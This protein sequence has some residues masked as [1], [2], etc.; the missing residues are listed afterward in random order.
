[1]LF[2]MQNLKFESYKQTPQERFNRSVSVLI[3]TT[4]VFLI[5]YLVTF[6]WFGEVDYGDQVVTVGNI[7]VAVTTDLDF[8]G[9]YLEPNKIY[10]KSTT[11]T[12]STQS[13]DENTNDAYIKVKLETSITIDGNPIITPIYN[14]TNWVYDGSEWYYYI[15]Y[16]NT[17]TPAVFNT[18][19]QV[20]NELGNDL[21]G[22]SLTLTLTVS[23]LQRDYEAY[24]YDTEWSSAP[25]AWLTAIATYDVTN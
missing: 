12:G 10:N 1:M 9:T 6:S 13:G 24:N 19:L 23:A 3:I 22:Q 5:L 20:S 14:E 15:G 17:T 7:S 11:I 2:V 21:Q 8:T 4:L 18:Q 16:I 25:A